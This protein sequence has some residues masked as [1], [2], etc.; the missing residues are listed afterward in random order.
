MKDQFGIGHSYAYFEARKGATFSNTL[1]FGIRYYLKMIEGCVVT[2]ES[3][4]D[5]ERRI[6][7][8]YGMGAEFPRKE[9]EYI[10][11]VHGGKLPVLIKS[12]TRS[13]DG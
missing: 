9:W 3:I 4:N 8:A 1:F 5:A 11:L 13:A 6:K 12:V 7:R 10:V 2:T